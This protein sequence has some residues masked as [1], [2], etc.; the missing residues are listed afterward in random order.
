MLWSMFSN[1]LSCLFWG[2]LMPYGF[3]FV[4][5][6]PV[7]RVGAF[8]HWKG[9]RVDELS[10]DELREAFSE[11]GLRYTRLLN[12]RGE[13]VTREDWEAS[14]PEGAWNAETEQSL[15]L[16]LRRAYRAM[17]RTREAFSKERRRLRAHLVF[18]VAMV[19]LLFLHSLFS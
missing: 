15:R 1:E 4:Q 13:P 7:S 9:K 10:L 12:S 16:A 8:D 14:D 3:G 5:E 2:Q 18:A 17:W 6:D 11:L 19:V